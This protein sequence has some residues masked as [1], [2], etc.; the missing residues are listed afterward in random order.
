[1]TQK[2]V[3]EMGR[4]MLAEGMSPIEVQQALFRTKGVKVAHILRFNETAYP[5]VLA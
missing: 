5:K 2:M 1:M 4:K 3:N